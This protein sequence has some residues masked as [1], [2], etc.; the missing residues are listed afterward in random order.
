M[1]KTEAMRRLDAIEAEAKALRELIDKPE[2]I[3][4]NSTRGIFV[5]QTGRDKYILLGDPYDDDGGKYYWFSL[6]YSCARKSKGCSGQEAIDNII[7]NGYV[8]R[9]FDSKEKALK[10][11][12]EGL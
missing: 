2:K 7:N 4:F 3:V 6:D 5:A 11:M 9:V 10:F 12:L 8:V 1:N